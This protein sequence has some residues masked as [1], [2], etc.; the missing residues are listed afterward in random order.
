MLCH[1]QQLRSLSAMLPVSVCIELKRICVPLA[2]PAAVDRTVSIGSHML[3][4]ERML[5]MRRPTQRATV[6]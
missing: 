5:L 6:H 3:A 1:E 2:V 4:L